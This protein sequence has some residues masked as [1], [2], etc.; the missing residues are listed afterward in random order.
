MH[1]CI[2]WLPLHLTSVW[3]VHLQPRS[4][5]HDVPPR[6]DATGAQGWDPSRG[7]PHPLPLPAVCPSPS[8]PTAEETEPATYSP[9]W[10]LLLGCTSVKA[11]GKKK[12]LKPLNLLEDGWDHHYQPFLSWILS[13]VKASSSLCFRSALAALSY[14]SSCHISPFPLHPKGKWCLLIKMRPAAEAHLLHAGYSGILSLPPPS[15][16]YSLS[17]PLP[18]PRP[19]SVLNHLAV[20]T[21]KK[22]AIDCPTFQPAKT[23]LA[24]HFHHTLHPK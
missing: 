17:L 16:L 10:R 9:P 6:R 20:S 1:Q 18:L 22:K 3:P 14:C 23:E 4:C 13:P 8:E 7:Y 19:L 2:I 5:C 24:S 11:T 15:S 21:Q 12:T